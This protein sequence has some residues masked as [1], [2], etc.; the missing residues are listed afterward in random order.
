M[1]NFCY[2][3]GVINH[4]E[5]DCRMWV[6]SQGTLKEDQQYGAWLWATTE[7]FQVSYVV[8]NKST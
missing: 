2:W 7:R 6:S 1:S 8:Q 5:K 3:C 4:D